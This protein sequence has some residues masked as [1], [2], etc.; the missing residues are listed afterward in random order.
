MEKHPCSFR[1][2]HFSIT[3][4]VSKTAMSLAIAFALTLFTTEAAHAQ[5][6]VLHYFGGGSDGAN[7]NAGV[8][9][10]NSGALYG[11]TQGGGIRPAI[12]MVRA[13]IFSADK[14][15]RYTRSA[16]QV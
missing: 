8:T 2:S 5:Y 10:G 15:A 6:Q 3:C 4:R 12:Y 1:K 14:A 11:T 16:A 9:V 7:P 13:R